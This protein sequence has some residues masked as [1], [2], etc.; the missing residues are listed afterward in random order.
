MKINLYSN[1]KLLKSKNLIP[2]YTWLVLIFIVSSIPHLKVTFVKI[3]SMD[4]IAHFSE[5]FIF[6]LL[7]KNGLYRE[8]N[9]RVR[10]IMLVIA[11]TTIF[12]TLDEIHQMIVPGRTAS[13]YDFIADFLGGAVFSQIYEIG[14]RVKNYDK[15][16]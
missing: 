15:S 2:A 5:Y 11:A 10:N 8:D 13:V 7:F 4:K 3:L 1:L 9:N 16:N 14:V 6:G 12:A